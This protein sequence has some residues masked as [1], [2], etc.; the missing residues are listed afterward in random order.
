[1]DKLKCPARGKQCNKCKA[2]NPF[3][4]K[5]PKFIQ[6]VS[7]KEEDPI[8]SE[9][10]IYGLNNSSRKSIRSKMILDGNPI[11][12]NVDSG[13]AL[14][15]I[16]QKYVKDS[17][18]LDDK[19][20]LSMW[21]KAEITTIGKAKLKIL[22][23]KTGLVHKVMFSINLSP[24]IGLTAAEKMNLL[25]INEENF[26]KVCSVTPTFTEKYADVF[27]DKLGCLPSVISLKTDSTVTPV[28]L[29]PR[30]VPISQKQALKAELNR[31]VD[32][33]VLTPVSEPSQLVSQ[34]VTREQKS[35]DLRICIDSKYLNKALLRERYP[36]PVMEDILNDLA[37]SR[38]FP[39]LDLA[40]SQN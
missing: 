18:I 5:C 9:D 3:A 26:E 12:F 19:Q 31:L 32:L 25:A 21:N 22:N 23:P 1:M 33:N 38:V 10:T 14:N 35:G 29:P 16:P 36:L 13:A 39:K 30:R 6:K 24:L 28:V 11:N 8:S 17:T 4:S 20:T 7:M 34:H 2:M 27:D 15:L 37:S 40:N